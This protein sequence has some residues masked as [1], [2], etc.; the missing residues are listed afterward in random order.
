M[1]QF[2]CEYVILYKNG[3]KKWACPQ[4]SAGNT[5]TFNSISAPGAMGRNSWCHFL[6]FQASSGA[7]ATDLVV[8]IWDALHV[9]PRVSERLPPPVSKVPHPSVC[10]RKKCLTP[11]ST[12]GA[13]RDSINTRIGSCFFNNAAMRNHRGNGNPLPNQDWHSCN[14]TTMIF[15]I[16]SLRQLSPLWGE[17]HKWNYYDTLLQHT[18]AMQYCNTLMQHTTETCPQGETHWVGSDL[19]GINELMH[20]FASR[21]CQVSHE[22]IMPH[23]ER[24]KFHCVRHV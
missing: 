11:L 20:E 15:R 21:T 7:S 3:P 17:T 14:D 6:E 18:T 4:S 24:V 9:M 12:Y 5:T 23:T 10:I 8:G 13:T 22:R 19:I 1:G 16:P 2:T